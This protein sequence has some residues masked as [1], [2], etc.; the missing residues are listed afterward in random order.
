[1]IKSPKHLIISPNRIEKFKNSISLLKARKRG[2]IKMRMDKKAQEM[3][4]T[5]IIVIILALLVLI[6]IAAAFSGGFAQLWAKIGEVLKISGAS[7]QDVIAQ[8]CSSHCST[9]SRVAFCQTQ[10]TVEGIDGK[11]T[12]WQLMSLIPS[13]TCSNAAELCK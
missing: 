6:I 11:K 7:T 8:T 2:E 12:C 10:Y 5:T 13:I 1:M 3:N 9:G 4:I